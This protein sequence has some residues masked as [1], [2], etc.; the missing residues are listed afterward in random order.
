[1]QVN[2]HNLLLA[3]LCREI[4][5]NTSKLHLLSLLLVGLA[6]LSRPG[7]AS[8][9]KKTRPTFLSSSSGSGTPSP[10]LPRDGGSDRRLQP[11]GENGGHG[12]GDRGERGCAQSGRRPRGGR[13]RMR[14]GR[15]APGARTSAWCSLSPP[16]PPWSVRR[17]QRSSATPTRARP[18]AGSLLLLF[19]HLTPEAA[20]SRQSSGQPNPATASLC[21][22]NFCMFFQIAASTSPRTLSRRYCS[23]ACSS[24]AGARRLERAPAGP[25][26]GPRRRMGLAPRVHAAQ[27]HV[28]VARTN[29]GAKDPMNDSSYFYLDSSEEKNAL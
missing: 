27:V 16:P 12:G 5:T 24:T 23:P 7:A 1:M 15:W 6:L 20:K 13:R 25:I 14:G 4:E 11:R 19:L 26:Q 8:P 17:S 22:S 3:W 29:G 18:S 2:E 28:R 10:W 21:T 9:W